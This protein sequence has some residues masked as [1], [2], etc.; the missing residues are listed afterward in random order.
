VNP[1]ESIPT[2]VTAET[3]TVT[4]PHT[5][6][7]PVATF[8]AAPARLTVTETVYYQY[9]QDQPVQASAQFGRTLD[10]EEQAYQRKVTVG[11]DWKPLD[12]GWAGPVPAMLVVA[13][14]EHR[15]VPPTIPT[16]EEAAALEAK[17]VEVG[18]TPPNGAVVGFARVRP[19]ET[20]RFEPSARVVVRCP[21]GRCRVVVFAAPG[22]REGGAANG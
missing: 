2:A 22:G 7:K 3:I 12:V 8:H 1:L 13:N 10:T 4:S 17:V 5:P 19:R 18:V 11:E 21:A 20:C 14:D 16:P 6:A 9:G 15:Y